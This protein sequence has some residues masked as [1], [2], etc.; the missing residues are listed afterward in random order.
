MPPVFTYN[1]TVTLQTSDLVNL[2]AQ[3]LQGPGGAKLLLD[4]PIPANPFTLDLAPLLAQITDPSWILI[5]AAAGVQ[6]KTDAAVAYSVKAAKV[7]MVQFVNNTPGPSGV[8]SVQV[9]V[10]TQVATQQRL[11]VLC[12]GA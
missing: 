2:G 9:Q 12:V 8:A 10:P 3:V 11:Q 7:I 5:V 4:E 6:F 1:A